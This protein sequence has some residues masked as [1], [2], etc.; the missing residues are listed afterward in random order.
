M[1]KIYLIEKSLSLKKLITFALKIYIYKELLYEN[2]G[3][4]LL[5]I[6]YVNVAL[7]DK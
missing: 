6:H 1:Y 2:Y 7:F 3:L 4:I 5:P